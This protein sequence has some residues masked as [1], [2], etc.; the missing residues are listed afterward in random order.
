[1]AD[2]AHL[3]RLMINFWL[4][5]PIYGRFMVDGP[6]LGQIFGYL[7]NKKFVCVAWAHFMAITGHPIFGR[8]FSA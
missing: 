8:A 1:M 5:D 4:M 6:H 2:G 3:C 7:Y